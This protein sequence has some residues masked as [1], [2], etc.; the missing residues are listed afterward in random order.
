MALTLCGYYIRESPVCQHAG[1]IFIYGFPA[2]K[3]GPPLASRP[4]LWYTVSR[5]TPV[6]RR[7]GGTMERSATAFGHMPDGTPVELLTLRD[8]ACTCDVITY[9]AAVRSLSVPAR[10]GTPV[11]VALGFD[12]LEDYRAQD[13]FI[14]ALIGRYANRIGGAGFSLN[15]RSYSL[16][17]NDGANSLHGGPTGFHAQVWAVEALDKNSVTLALISPDMHEGYPGTLEARVTYTLKDGAL[18]IGYR[19]KSDKDTVCNLTNHSYFNLSGHGSGSVES[20]Y[21]RLHASRYTPTLPGS[22]PTGALAPVEGTVMDLRRPQP[23]GACIDEPF[24]QLAL[25]GGW[26][27]NWVIDGWDGKLRSAAW[28]WAPDTGIALEAFT[29]L[30]GIQF[31][32]GNYLNDCPAGKGGAPYAKRWGFCLE[33]QYFPDS[34]NQPGFPSCVLRSGEEYRSTTV[35]RFCAPDPSGLDLSG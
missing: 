8:G 31:Y 28:A 30:P 14:G 26:D 10:D 9:G 27:H 12:T 4:R 21:I 34:P 2:E 32:A 13:K 17:A 15:G 22:I 18:A 19:A 24:E 29:T 20:Q 11:D 3:T 6:S 1:R 23:I 35:Y 7:I 16:S 5:K 33:T 25:A